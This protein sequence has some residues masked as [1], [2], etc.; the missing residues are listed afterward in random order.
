MSRA[1]PWA[2]DSQSFWSRGSEMSRPPPLGSGQSV[3]L[4]QGE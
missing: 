4:E 2:A 1:P 3:I